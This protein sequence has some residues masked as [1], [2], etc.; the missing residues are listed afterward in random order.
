MPGMI[1]A[2]PGTNSIF[3]QLQAT[4]PPHIR[5]SDARWRR[6]CSGFGF[7]W[8]NDRKLNWTYRTRRQLRYPSMRSGF[9]QDPASMVA[10]LSADVGARC[11]DY[12][13]RRYGRGSQGLKFIR[14]RCKDSGGAGISGAVVQGFLTATD[15]YVGETA[16]DSSGYYEFGTPFPSPA[17]HYLV[18]YR[19]GSPDIAG[20]TVN[21]LTP[22]NR[23]GT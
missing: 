3:A 9:A 5:G 11:P 19:S 22:A 6:V 14:G 23:D 21:T 12:A 16:A 7:S 17:Q 4:V 13:P 20:T 18:A 8:A 2:V 15:A 10:P 1:L